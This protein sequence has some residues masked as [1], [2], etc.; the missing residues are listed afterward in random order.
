MERKGDGPWSTF[1][2]E[3]YLAIQNEMVIY[4]SVQEKKI[5]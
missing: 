3:G 5:L 4:F 2:K 1:L